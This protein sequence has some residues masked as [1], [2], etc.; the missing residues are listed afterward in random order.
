M[1]SL[2]RTKRIKTETAIPI[3]KIKEK[4]MKTEPSSHFDLLSNTMTAIQS[5]K[6]PSNF[7][8]FSLYQ[9]PHSIKLS[10]K[11]KIQQR[12]IKKTESMP[13]P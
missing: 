4:N 12:S 1:S 6:P 5:T 8:Q 11:S 3:A 2:H 10:L 13:Q 7:K 9:Q